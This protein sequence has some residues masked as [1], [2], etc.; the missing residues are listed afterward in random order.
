MMRARGF[1]IVNYVDDY[2]GFGVPSVAECSFNALYNLL[3]ALG[4]TISAKKLVR[5]T[6]RAICLGV[7]IDSESGTISIPEDKLHQIKQ[8]VCEWQTKRSCTCRQL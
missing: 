5:P 3:H 2:V 4:F 1:Q 8:N 6:T 7:L